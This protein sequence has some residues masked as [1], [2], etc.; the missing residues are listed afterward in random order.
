[1]RKRLLDLKKL[2]PYHGAGILFWTRDQQGRIFV[3]LGMR[4]HNP[5]KGKWSIPAGGW[6]DEDSRDE[7]GRPDYRKTAIRETWEEI[8]FTVDNP[9]K[10][11]SLW[12][13]HLPFFH[14]AVYSY[15]LPEQEAVVRYQEF[16]EVKWFS[17][18]V[19]PVNSVGLVRS[20]VAALVRQHPKG[21]I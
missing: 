14:F 5:Q 6:E 8:Q 18:D 3:L 12:S 2:R 21:K 9:D 20:Q 10:L 15:Q 7:K 4:K 13:K 17:V 11:V 16:S 1:M 19:L